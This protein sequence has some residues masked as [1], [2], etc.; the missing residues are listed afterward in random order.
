MFACWVT[1]VGFNADVLSSYACCLDYVCCCLCCLNWLHCVSSVWLGWSILVAFGNSVVILILFFCV[2][3]GFNDILL[4]FEWFAL[5]CLFTRV[6][7]WFVLVC[8][9]CYLVFVAFGVELFDYDLLD[10]AVYCWLAWIWLNFGY[11]LVCGCLFTLDC[12]VV[13][14]MLL[15][16]FLVLDGDLRCYL[17]LLFSVCSCLISVLFNF[18]FGLY[19]LWVFGLVVC[20]MLR[21]GLSVNV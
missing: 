7:L 19:W 10:I 16:L 13:I 12:F 8:W 5:L 3:F 1:W 9:N 15:R 20:Y 2:L 21:F 6:L 18:G 4:R 17:C 14:T 11:G